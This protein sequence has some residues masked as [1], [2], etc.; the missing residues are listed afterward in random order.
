MQFR[1]YKSLIFNYL[2]FAKILFCVP[3]GLFASTLFTKFL[4]C[5]PKL[6]SIYYGLN[7]II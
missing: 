1:K 3:I 5:L 7:Y 2:Q 4:A 6:Q